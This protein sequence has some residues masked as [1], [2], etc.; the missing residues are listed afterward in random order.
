MAIDMVAGI[1][2][3]IDGTIATAT[4][5]AATGTGIEIAIAIVAPETGTEIGIGIEAAVR[6]TGQ[7]QTTNQNSE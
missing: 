7:L 4:G 5:I 1:G 3:E 2:S 6:E